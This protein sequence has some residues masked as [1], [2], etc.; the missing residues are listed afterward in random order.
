MDPPPLHTSPRAQAL[1]QS[2][3]GSNPELGG[4]D[5]DPEHPIRES[6]GEFWGRTAAM[7]LLHCVP[8]FC[9]GMTF[10]QMG[11]GATVFRGLA[12]SHDAASYVVMGGL[13]FAFLLYCYDISYWRGAYGRFFRTAFIFLLVF[14]FGVGAVRFGA[15]R[16]QPCG[17]LRCLVSWLCALTRYVF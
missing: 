1:E 9:F 8:V 4:M 14:D 7:L 11:Y 5:P 6:A 17:G 12:E 10:T 3:K 13:A 16:S 15:C 2:H